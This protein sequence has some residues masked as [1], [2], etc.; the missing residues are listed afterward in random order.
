MPTT[1]LDAEACSVL[2]VDDE[3]MARKW[4][5]RTF[6]NEFRIEAVP[7]VDAALVVLRERGAQFAVLVTDSRM[8][9]KCGMDL[10]RIVQREHRHLVPLL[11]TAYADK[12]MAIAAVNEGHVFRIL[13]KPLDEHAARLAL[14]Q[15]LSLYRSRAHERALHESR[16]IAMRETLGFLAHELNTPLATVRGYMRALRDRY[17]SADAAAGD[18]RAS[19]CEQQPGEIIAAIDAAERRALY[20][21]S[22]VSTFVQSARNAYPGG[23]ER[24]L[25]ASQ[26]LK[27]LVNEYPFDGLEHDWV[28]L[29]PHEDFVLPGRRDLLYLVLCSLTKNALQALHG[30]DAPRLRI[31]F[32]RSTVPGLPVHPWIRFC[33]NGPGIAPDILARLTVEPVTTR[34]DVGGHGMGLMFCSRVMQSMGG[35]IEINS[36]PGEGSRVSLNFP[37]IEDARA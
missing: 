26:L 10:L 2:L 1:T 7:G 14:R 15:A 16:A 37:C 31:E 3:A 21:Q 6:E 35:S 25:N 19:F 27:S 32:G 28:L 17:Q 9:H 29:C 22:L 34:A 12:Q 23:T 36:E 33:D 11:C 20:C 4:F 18:G 13:E 24:A 30:R 5:C 8:P